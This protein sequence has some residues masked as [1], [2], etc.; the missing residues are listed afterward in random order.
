[1]ENSLEPLLLAFLGHM[2][3]DYLL[4]TDWMAENKKEQTWPCLVHSTIWAASVVL[5]AGWLSWIPFL[6]LL[7]IHFL[8]DRTYMVRSWM[9][10]TG[11]EHFIDGDYAPWSIVIVDNTFHLLQIWLVWKF[12]V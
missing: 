10:L 5:F 11:Q 8:Q 7:A 2:V 1:M 6:V 12:L 4:Q 3:G 9:R